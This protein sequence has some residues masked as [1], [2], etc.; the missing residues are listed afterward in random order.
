MLEYIV[1]FD[2]H[3]IYII[4]HFGNLSYLILFAVI[5]AETGLVVTPFLP[6]DSL[7]FVIGTLS[8]TGV[9]H[10]I[11][12]AVVLILAAILGDSINYTVGRYLGRRLIEGKHSRLIN[13]EYLDRT[14]HFFKKY[15]GKTIILA[16]FVPMVR[17]FAP[18]VA[19]FIHMDYP[20]FFFYNVVGGITWVAI[21][22]AAG[23]YFGNIQ[24]VKDNLSLVMLLIII[25]SVLPAIFEVMKVKRN[26][27]S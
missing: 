22:V 5:F 27:R 15:G 23:F 1:H 13:K 14:H 7:L 18:F 12:V 6:G 21:F 20:K 2:K 26:P 3:L 10:P 16:R 4:Q 11:L 25:L 17:T 19:G 8:A 24:I 9:F